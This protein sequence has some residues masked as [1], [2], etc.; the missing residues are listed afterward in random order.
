MPKLTYTSCSY[1]EPVT[2]EKYFDEGC[3][4]AGLLLR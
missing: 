2:G 4:I 3:V 1:T